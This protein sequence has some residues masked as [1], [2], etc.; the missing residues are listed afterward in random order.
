MP[1]RGQTHSWIQPQVMWAAQM[2]NHHRIVSWDEDFDKDGK[3]ETF[4][5]MARER[6]LAL[7]AWCGYMQ[8]GKQ[9]GARHDYSIETQRRST[10]EG[11][12]DEGTKVV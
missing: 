10:W 6:R 4:I 9:G 5:S 2:C 7:T 8:C 11:N 3:D 12:V 1:F